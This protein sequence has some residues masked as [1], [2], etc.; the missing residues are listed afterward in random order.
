VKLLLEKRITDYGLRMS[1]RQSPD[2]HF[3]KSGPEV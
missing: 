2:L 1:K 3:C